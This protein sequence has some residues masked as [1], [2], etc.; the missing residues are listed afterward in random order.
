[1]HVPG[2]GADHRQDAVIAVTGAP[3]E[4][5]VNG[6]ARPAVDPAALKAGDEL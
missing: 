1:M 4:V 5:K 3:V 2:P 6:E